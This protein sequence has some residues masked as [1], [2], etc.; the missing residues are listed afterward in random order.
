MDEFY[1]GDRVEF[2]YEHALNKG[3]LLPGSI[4]TV[5]AIRT[6]SQLTIGVKWD[7]EMGGHSLEKRCELGHGWWVSKEHIALHSEETFEPADESRLMQF[8]FDR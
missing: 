4:G 8:L 7:K 1:I 3:R 2:I 5:I 6:N